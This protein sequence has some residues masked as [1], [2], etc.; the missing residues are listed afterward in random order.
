MTDGDG[1]LENLPHSRPGQRSDK[2]AAKPGEPAKASRPAPKRAKPRT[3]TKNAAAGSAAKGPKTRAT[4]K[5]RATPKVAKAPAEKP[6]PASTDSGGG[7]VLGA[8]SSAAGSVARVA[9]GI[10]REVLRR[11]PRP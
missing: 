5:P 1:V 6:P 10:S 9:Q 8:V 3:A 7:S 2:R 11:V 4:P